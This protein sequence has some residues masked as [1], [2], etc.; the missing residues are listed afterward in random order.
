MLE[1]DHKKS[2]VSVFAQ[3]TVLENA[4]AKCGHKTISTMGATA[5]IS[6]LEGETFS[7]SCQATGSEQPG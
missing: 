1:H 5:L 4:L 2:A 7:P 6:E 3:N